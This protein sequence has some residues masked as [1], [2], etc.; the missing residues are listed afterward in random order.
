MGRPKLFD[1]DKVLAAAGEMFRARGYEATS[2]R[3]LTDCTG[4]TPSSLYNAFGDKRGL[5]RRALE[6]YLNATLHER[7]ARLEATEP[8]GRAI[9][10][11]FH[12]VIE[13]SL[14]DPQHRGCLLV[15]TALE[16][17][18]EEPELQGYVARETAA[19]E[20]FFHRCVLAAQAGGEI[21]ATQPAEDL[22]RMLLALLLGLRV[23][24]RVRPG[25]DLLTGLARPGMAMLTLPWP[26]EEGRAP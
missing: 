20:G 11:F 6:H 23:L 16:T 9:A 24:A 26:P 21:P 13:R 7:I 2:T 5:H 8:P 18:A 22:A 17:T 10:G 12:E 14:A 19:L 25:R 3:D 1:E 4:L 15:N